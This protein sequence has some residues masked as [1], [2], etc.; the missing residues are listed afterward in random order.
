MLTFE[1]RTSYGKYK[2]V[3]E[4]EIQSAIYFDELLALDAQQL[5]DEMN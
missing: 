2:I 4:Y 1:F 5:P 3:S